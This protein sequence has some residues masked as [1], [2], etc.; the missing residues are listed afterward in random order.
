MNNVRLSHHPNSKKNGTY[1]VI[2]KNYLDL[3]TSFDDKKLQWKW[4]K[5]DKRNIKRIKKKKQKVG[6]NSTEHS[7]QS[8]TEIIKSFKYK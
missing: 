4:D 1:Y 7:G 2:P 5:N 3:F 8:P 6:Y